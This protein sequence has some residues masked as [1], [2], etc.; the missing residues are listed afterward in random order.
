MSHFSGETAPAPY[1]T[2]LMEKN[3]SKPPAEQPQIPPD[4]HLQNPPVETQKVAFKLGG[5]EETDLNS[6]IESKD[7]DISNGENF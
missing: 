1:E 3:S 5:S 6:D 2:P 7:L 4:L